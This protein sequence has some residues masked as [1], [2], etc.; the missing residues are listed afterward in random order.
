[1]NVEAFCYLGLLRFPEQLE[2]SLALLTDEHR[3]EAKAFLDSVRGAPK[4]QLTER[5]SSLRE[6][7]FAALEQQSREKTGITLDRLPSSIRT[8]WACWLSEHE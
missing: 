7:E 8:Y 1:M 4:A 3:L 2:P 5:W 6:A